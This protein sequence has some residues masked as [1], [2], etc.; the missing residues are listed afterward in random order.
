MTHHKPP[1]SKSTNEK[2]LNGKWLNRKELNQQVAEL[3]AV[4]LQAV[5]REV[6]ERQVVER[7]VVE[8]TVE[9]TS[10][11]YAC[12]LDRI[13]TI[14]GWIEEAPVEFQSADGVSNAGVLMGLALLEETH[15][16]EE[17]RAVYGRLKNGWYGL[18]SLL[19]TLVIMALLR[20]KR[21]EQLKHHDPAA[22]A[23]YWDCLAPP[24]SKRCVA[25]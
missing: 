18:R 8:A 7:Q 20:I 2:R 3:Q 17:A 22:W 21:P 4:E 6:V 16:L 23:V 10:I 5:E 12:P 1:V 25:S 9:A 11:P 15:L 14:L 19:W 13:A 24:K